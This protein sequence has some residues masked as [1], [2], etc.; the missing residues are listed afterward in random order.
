MK[1]NADSIINIYYAREFV[2]IYYTVKITSLYID[3]YI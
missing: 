3:I 2:I 1:I